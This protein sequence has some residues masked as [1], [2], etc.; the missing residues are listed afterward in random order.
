MQPENRV[1]LLRGNGRVSGTNS[2]L[3]HY[4]AVRQVAV[5]K[6]HDVRSYA[7][8]AGVPNLL[9]LRCPWSRRES[10]Y[11]S[12]HVQVAHNVPGGMGEGVHFRVLLEN[13]CDQAKQIQVGSEIAW[14]SQGVAKLT[15]MKQKTRG[16]VKT[17]ASV[18]L[19]CT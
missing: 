15:G 1:V 11:R 10:A 17:C 14:P 5:Q 2:S 7:W 12:H 18:Q 4:D 6:V 19:K 16:V 9:H 3:S 13:G 8:C